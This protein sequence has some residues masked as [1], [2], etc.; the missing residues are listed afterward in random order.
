MSLTINGAV[1]V[2]RGM[3]DALDMKQGTAG[4]GAGDRLARFLATKSIT[5]Y[6]AD[7]LREMITEP[8]KFKV[9]GSIA[10]GYEATIL[11][12]ICGAVLDARRIGKLNY[13]QEHIA[14]R[15]EMLLRGFAKVGIVALV[16]E[17]T[18][19]Q[20]ERPRRDL[21]EQLKKFL[22][23]SLRKWVR[24]FPAD[25]LKHLCRLRGVELRP[26]MKLPPY[27]GHLTN[28]LIYRRI[29]PGLVK[30]LKERREERGSPSNKLHSWLSE[31]FGV[32][33]LLVHSGIVIGLMK[34]HNDYKSFEKSLDTIAPIYPEV[35]GLFDKASDWE[36]NGKV[37]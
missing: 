3:M 23:E 29:A 36:D 21:E 12:D 5:D 33:E 4:R 1:L 32:K 16:D 9:G 27:F 14:E 18:G 8:I 30:R 13:Q 7:S 17:A 19:F 2:Q 35:P 22:S 31:D 34:T 25:Y 10:Y 6:V 26:D 11:A 20:Y 15:C 24:T 28:N 37:E